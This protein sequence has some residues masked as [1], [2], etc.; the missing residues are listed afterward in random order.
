MTG[1]RARDAAYFALTLAV[2][3]LIGLGVVLTSAIQ[4]VRRDLE[5]VRRQL[6]AWRFEEDGSA[7]VQTD[8]GTRYA[9]LYEHGYRA[10]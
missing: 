2:V 1:R 3:T 7:S 5:D 4:D 10:R 6:C 9:C 8:D